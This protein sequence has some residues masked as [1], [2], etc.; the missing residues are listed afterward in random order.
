M[1]A[2]CY[3]TTHRLHSAASLED[4]TTWDLVKDI[5]VLRKHLGFDNWHVFGGSWVAQPLS[6]LLQLC[7]TYNR[8]QGSTLSLAY[9]QVCMKYRVF[10][11][12]FHHLYFSRTPTE[13]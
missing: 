7:S 2:V 4:N 3:T 10:Y 12:C 13:Y 11:D 1:V 9:A 8:R 5:E 6:A